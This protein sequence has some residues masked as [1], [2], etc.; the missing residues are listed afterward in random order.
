MAL[1]SAPQAASG[2]AATAS[3]DLTEFNFA[4]DY[5][6]WFYNGEKHNL[7]LDKLSTITGTRLPVMTIEAASDAYLAVHEADLRSG[8]PL[9]LQ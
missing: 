5:T 3:A 1:I 6:A 9:R 8:E 7:G 4:G 2:E